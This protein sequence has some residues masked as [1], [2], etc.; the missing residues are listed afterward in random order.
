MM[1]AKQDITLRKQAEDELKKKMKENEILLERLSVILNTL[2][3]SVALLN[4]QGLVVEVN[5]AWKKFADE[6]GFTDTNYGVNNSYLT[7][8][9]QSFG[10]KEA[11]GKTISQG[12]SAV[13]Q[14]NAPLFEFEYPWH[15]PGLP[16]WFRIVVTP[17]RGQEFTGAVVMNIDISDIRRLEKERIESKIEAISAP[18]HGVWRRRYPRCRRRQRMLSPASATPRLY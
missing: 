15:L 10:N 7:I 2:P 17:L 3:A 11:H 14:G 12:I 16:R 6:N 9:T 4:E 18:R 1:G 8:S 13:L 5:E